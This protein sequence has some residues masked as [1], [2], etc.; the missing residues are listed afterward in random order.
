M[1]RNTGHLALSALLLLAACDQGRTRPPQPVPTFPKISRFAADRTT[2]ARGEKVTL[3]Y[4]VTD[5]DTVEIMPDVLPAAPILEGTVQT[6]ALDQTTTFT[7]KA[8]SDAGET[9]RQVTVSVTTP[10]N[11]VHIIS[12]SAAPTTLAPGASATLSWEVE[13]STQ[14]KVEVMGGA[15]LVNNADPKASLPVQPSDTTTYVLTAQ[16]PGGPATSMA[17]VSIGKLPTITDFTAMP[18]EVTAGATSMLSWHTDSATGVRI[19]DQAG[20]ELHTAPDAAGTFGVSPTATTEYTLEAHNDIGAVTS[21]TTVRVTGADRPTINSFSADPT[22]VLGSGDVTIQ[23]MTTMADTVTLSADSGA[24]AGFPGGP[25]G[26]F[27][28]NVSTTTNFVLHATNTFG[29]TTQMATVTVMPLPDTTP[30]VLMHTPSLNTQVAGTPVPIQAN[31]SDADSGLEGVTLYYRAT[32]TMTFQSLAMTAGAGDLW[33]ATIPGAAVV[34]PGVDYYLEARDRASPPNRST[35][36]AMAPTNVHTFGVMV[37]DT[38]PPTITHTPIANGQLAGSPITVVATIVDADSGV[39]A[40]TLHYRAQGAPS[41]Q[42]RAMMAMAMNQFSADIPAAAVVPGTLEYYIDASDGASPPNSANFPAAAPAQLVSF[43][44]TALDTVPPVIQHTPVAGTQTANGAVQINATVTDASGVQS[45]TLYYRTQGAGAYATVLLTGTG[46]NYAGSIPAPAVQPPAVEYYLEA[47]DSAMVPNTG[48]AP[49]T[50]PATPYSFAVQVADMNAPQIV[51]TQVTSPRTPGQAVA[52]SAQITDASGIASATLF[53]RAQGASSFTSVAMTGGP[54]FVANIPAAAV[55][56]PGIEYYI[57]AQDSAAAMNAGTSPANAPATTFAFVIGFSENEPNN[58][59]ATATVLLTGSRTNSM[60]IGSISP[61]ADHDYWAIDIPGG[62]TRYDL[63][64]EITSGGPGNCPNPVDTILRL[65]DSTG[66]NQLVSDSFDGVGSCSLID[67][68]TDAAARSLAPGRYYLRVEENGDNATIGTYELTVTLVPAVCGNGI[69]EPGANEQCDDHNTMAGDGCSSTC[70]IEPEGVLTPPSGVFSGDITPTTDTDLYAVDASMG[71]FLRAEVTDAAGTGCPGDLALDLIGP[72]GTTVLGSDDDSGNGFCPL[73]NPLTNAFARALAAGRYFVRVRASNGTDVV[74]AYRLHLDLTNNLCGDGST[75][76]GEQCDDSNTTAGDGCSATCQFETIATAS[77]TGGTFS[78]AITPIGNRDFYAVTV[79]Q[80]DSI[81]AETFAP[82]AGQCTTG[83]DTVIRL[84]PSDRSA[85][86][87]SDDESGIASC[88]LLD[89][90]SNLIMRNLNA[91]TYYISVEDFNNNGTI[92]AYVLDIQIRHMGCG[93][94]WL[95]G[96]DV[97]DDGNTMNGDGCSSTCRFEGAAEIE[98]NNTSANATALVPGGM[99]QGTLLGSISTGTDIDIYSVVVPAGYSLFAEVNDGMNGCPNTGTLRLR[100][101]NGTTSLAYDT[102]HGPGGT[103]G[104]ISPQVYTAARFMTGGTYYLE[105]SSTAGSAAY[106]LTAR[107][108]APGCGDGF[109]S[110]A[111]VCDDGNTMNGDGCS[112]SCLLEGSSEIEPN[113][114]IGN[115]TPIT[116]TSTGTTI[117]GILATAS[118]VDYFSFTVPAG[119]H[120]M[121]EVSDGRGG[122]PNSASLRLHGP[123]GTNLTSDSG[124]GPGNCGRISPGGDSA[125]RGLAA[126][127]YYFEVYGTTPTTD[128]YTLTVRVLAPTVCGNLYLDA[129]E[130]CDDGNAQNGDGCSS[131]CQWEGMETETNDAFGMANP[132]SG[133]FR[134]INGGLPMNSDVDWYAITVP[135]NGTVSAWTH[136]GQ[137]DVC[138]SIDTIIALFGP[139]GTTQLATS[140]DEGAGLCSYIDGGMAGP[141]AAGTYYLRV[142]PFGTRSFPSYGLTID[143]R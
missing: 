75:Q 44:V 3:S 130:Q 55:E 9:T 125:A 143:I 28:I 6:A 45:V 141:L 41:F 110:G 96:A 57:R 128:I 132:L 77:G 78:E 79:A 20:N 21:R 24:V 29:E 11:S 74:T 92:T 13:R 35:N 18:A 23:W 101:T 68:V 2:V 26:S 34:A 47:V 33:N 133:T 38:N 50:A 4:T 111:E 39:G 126:G 46:G 90:S 82:A 22:M 106:H 122:C 105:V 49:A 123:G 32:G 59:S 15:V 124:D 27:V 63:R 129:G 87:T 40:A 62:A 109:I 119:Y 25:S 60:G 116:A 7:L 86:I 94:G 95:D 17:T 83:N 135:Q 115:A 70:S 65:Y 19:L 42:T 56:P 10:E 93:N 85:Q 97:C 138:T 53:Y 31:A 76:A 114:G 8:V 16:G 134:T 98:P 69:L 54:T 37:A 99:T 61:T 108:L 52:V 51:H 72:D 91:G 107:V 127:T 120:V 118:D 89:P 12:F 131:T 84:W 64:A 139:D 58:S 102:T 5:A 88:S 140:D 71:Q 113:S 80:G 100:D 1:A 104:Q 73:I 30:P 36:P 66:T 43:T 14:I 142:T 121:G 137:I 103:C 81:R 67:P 48:R 117:R 112:A 136:T